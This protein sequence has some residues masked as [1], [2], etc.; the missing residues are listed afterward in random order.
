MQALAEFLSARA[1]GRRI[2]ALDVV[3]PKIVKAGVPAQAAGG[4][5]DAVE[6]RGKM[7]DIGVSSAASGPAHLIA[8]WGHDGWL[9]WHDVVPKGTRRTGEATLLAACGSTTARASI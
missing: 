2:A 6:R 3:L 8:H 1:V 5:I 4:L 9:L 7:L